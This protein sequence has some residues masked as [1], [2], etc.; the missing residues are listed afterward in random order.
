MI[1]KI[2]E[3]ESKK[4]FTMCDAQCADEY[5]VRIYSEAKM[6][7]KARVSRFLFVSNLFPSIFS[8][9]TN[10]GFWCFFKQKTTN[11]RK[12]FRKKTVVLCDD[13]DDIDDDDDAEK[14]G[15]ALLR[16]ILLIFFDDDKKKNEEP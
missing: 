13:D 1:P 6:K 2:S 14:R 15:R 10:L 16:V 4:E 12:L 8:L 7:H 3:K 5:C 11:E 9:N